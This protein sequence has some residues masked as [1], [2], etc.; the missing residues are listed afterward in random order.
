MAD[1]GRAVNTRTPT[2]LLGLIKVFIKLAKE[3]IFTPGADNR[4]YSVCPQAS[5]NFN[6]SYKGKYLKI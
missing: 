2:D 1:A 4:N 6:D 3:I 5:S